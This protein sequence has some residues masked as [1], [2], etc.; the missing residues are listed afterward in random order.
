MS[1]LLCIKLDVAKVAIAD[2]DGESNSGVAT[3]L[4]YCIS[5]DILADGTSLSMCIFS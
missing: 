1:Y 5:C 2:N 3:E 4:T